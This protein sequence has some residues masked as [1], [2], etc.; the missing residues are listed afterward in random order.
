MLVSVSGLV[1]QNPFL[2]ELAKAFTEKG[3]GWVMVRAPV[4]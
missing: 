2:C 4:L 3:K 1:A